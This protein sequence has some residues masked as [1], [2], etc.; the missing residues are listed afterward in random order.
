MTDL[1]KKLL[2]IQAT[3]KDLSHE[4]VANGGSNSSALQDQLLHKMRPLEIVFKQLGFHIASWKPENIEQMTADRE[5]IL[6]EAIDTIKEYKNYVVRNQKY[7]YAAALRGIERLLIND[8]DKLSE[9]SIRVI[10]QT[11]SF[12]ANNEAELMKSKSTTNENQDS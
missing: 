1:E 5:N 6:K 3:H 8:G 10:L 12:M 11:L 2:K 9:L 7:E 4:Y